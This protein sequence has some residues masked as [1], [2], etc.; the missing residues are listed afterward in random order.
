VK[1]RAFITLLGGAGRLAARRV[2][3]EKKAG[4]SFYGPINYSNTVC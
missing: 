3:R 1:R 2:L 4:S